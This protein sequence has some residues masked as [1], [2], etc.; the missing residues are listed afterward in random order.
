MTFVFETTAAQRF[1]AILY[2]SASDFAGGQDTWSVDIMAMGYY[3]LPTILEHQTYTPKNVY[4]QYFVIRTDGTKTVMGN[5]YLS[6]YDLFMRGTHGYPTGEVLHTV[7]GTR[8]EIERIFDE[9]MH[10]T[11]ELA[12]YAGFFTFTLEAEYQTGVQ[13]VYLGT[14][15]RRM[16]ATARHSE[17]RSIG[18]TTST[19]TPPVAF[20]IG[21]RTVTAWQNCCRGRNSSSRRTWFC[22]L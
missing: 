20:P 17:S 3:E 21:T 7:T 2:R 18:S 15:G 5:K 8:V 10:R 19:V 9:M 11:G 1:L 6:K 16:F 22:A 4:Y 13:K 14:A 12:E